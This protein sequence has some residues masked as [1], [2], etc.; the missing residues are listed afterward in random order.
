LI[1]SSKANKILE[2]KNVYSVVEAL[3]ETVLWYKNF[4]DNPKD[5][6]RESISQIEKYVSRAA[7]NN[8]IWSKEEK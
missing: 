1:N 2:W 3:E 6:E 5:I 4:Y 8:L 7:E